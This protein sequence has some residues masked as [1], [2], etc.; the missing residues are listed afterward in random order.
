MITENSLSRV[1]TELRLCGYE[2]DKLSPVEGRL[3]E[4]QGIELEVTKKGR[5]D[6]PD[7]IF[8]EKNVTVEV[9]SGDELPF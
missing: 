7:D 2:T 1:K 6:G 5:N 8:F 9:E 3:V 4:F